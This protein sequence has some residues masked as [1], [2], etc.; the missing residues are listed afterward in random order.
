VLPAGLSPISSLFK[1]V[2]LARNRETVDADRLTCGGGD[3]GA[4]VAWGFGLFSSFISFSTTSFIFKIPPT[5]PIIDRESSLPSKLSCGADAANGE[6]IR[7]LFRFFFR[8]LP[9]SIADEV[10]EDVDEDA[11][12]MN[13]CLR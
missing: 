5:S 11:V 1:P 13:I 6:N 3:T 2:L 10:S 7:F 12:R 8:E 4:D 9:R